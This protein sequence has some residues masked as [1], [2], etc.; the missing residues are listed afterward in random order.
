MEILQTLKN[1]F[2]E[3]IKETSDSFGMPVVVCEASASHKIISF[4]KHEPGLEFIQ[5][6]DLCGVDFSGDGYGLDE[7]P[8]RF[9]VV[10]HLYSFKSKSRIR[11]R[12]RLNAEKPVCDSICDLYK[13]ADW[14]ER[15]AYDM[16]GI[17]FTNHPRLTRLLMWPEFEGH[18]LR[19][20]YPM[21][22]RQPLPETQKDLLN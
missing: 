14:F 6:L 21:R 17:E 3:D 1:K 2:G 19:K 18:P 7:N 12:V 4:L 5:L 15:E 13:C 9:E 11:I 16:L 20:D 22:K 8:H 10:S